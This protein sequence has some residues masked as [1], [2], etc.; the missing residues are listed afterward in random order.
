MAGDK[1]AREFFRGMVASSGPGAW[2]AGQGGVGPS[3]GPGA[4]ESSSSGGPPAQ[5]GAGASGVAAGG[6]ASS[7]IAPP[8]PIVAAPPVVAAGAPGLPAPDSPAQGSPV[9]SAASSGFD[10][11]GV[12]PDIVDLQ[13]ECNLARSHFSAATVE[14]ENLWDSLQAVEVARGATEG[15]VRAARDA[16]ADAQAHAF[17]EFRS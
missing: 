9:V 14:I 17:D 8:P 10:S 1:R 5:D 12:N 7:S 4:S 15:E 13:R 16:A 11:G 6:S 3:G 2:I